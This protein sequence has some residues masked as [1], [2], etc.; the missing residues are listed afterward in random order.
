MIHAFVSTKDVESLKVIKNFSINLN[1][2]FLCIRSLK[3]GYQV[4]K[5]KNKLK[6][7]ITLRFSTSFVYKRVFLLL[8][9]W[10]IILRGRDFFS[11][12]NI[13]DIIKKR[14]AEKKISAS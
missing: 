5:I 13:K 10:Q 7:F 11:F 8:K 1:N 14:C 3:F 4:I 9:K 12:F 6:F 2:F